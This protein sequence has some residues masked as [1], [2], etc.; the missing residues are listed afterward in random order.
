MKRR[1]SKIQPRLCDRPGYP[2]KDVELSDTISDGDT[3]LQQK[4][5]SVKIMFVFVS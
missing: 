1:N 4:S 2:L 5:A 3:K